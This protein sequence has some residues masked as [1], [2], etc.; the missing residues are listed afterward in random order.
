MDRFREGVKRF[1]TEVFP[2][3]R[4]LF[5]SLARMQ[6]PSALFITCADSRIDPELLTQSGPG[7]IFVERNP[8][9]IVP[10]Y[11]SSSKVGV[12][13]SVEYAVSV[14][15]VKWIIVCGHSNCGAMK[16]LLRDP[17][18]LQNL[19]SVARWLSFGQPARDRLSADTRMS[20]EEQLER[21]TQLNV[22]EQIQHL[23]THPSV[24]RS[25]DLMIEGW[26]YEIHTGKVAAF[27]PSTGAFE[28]LT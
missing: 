2:A 18:Q 21:M 22:I 23:K 6:R 12:S 8:G 17:E 19:P 11:D 20:S 4:E 14:L 3:R 28:S 26:T 1:Q 16:A 7:E 15:N 9:N 25:T 13:A 10:I 24:A 5:E 27:N